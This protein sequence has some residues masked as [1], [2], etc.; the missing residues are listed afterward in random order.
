MRQ[1]AMLEIGKPSDR[2]KRQTPAEKPGGLEHHVDASGPKFRDS[3]TVRSER[4]R[5]HQTRLASI[6]CGRPHDF[7]AGN[8]G[9]RGDLI[10]GVKRSC[11]QDGRDVT[12]AIPV[13][14]NKKIA[15]IVVTTGPETA[16]DMSE[17]DAERSMISQ[18][19]AP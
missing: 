16:R 2:R 13:Q 3:Q 4:D 19:P 18:P 6:E 11:E 7:D 17:R 9:K 5:A 12:W 1:P 14:R 8:T 10:S 15:L